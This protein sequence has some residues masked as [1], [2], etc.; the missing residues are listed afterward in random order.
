MLQAQ[1]VPHQGV[2]Y[3][4]KDFIEFGKSIFSGVFRI[5]KHLASIIWNEFSRKVKKLINS[6]SLV[7]I[8]EI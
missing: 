7:R 3:T 1:E 6:E 5:T 2:K 4:R 8:H